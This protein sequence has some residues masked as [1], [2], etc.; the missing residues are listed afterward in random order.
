MRMSAGVARAVSG[1]SDL[2]AAPPVVYANPGSVSG[3]I[4]CHGAGEVSFSPTNSIYVGQYPLLNALASQYAVASGDFGGDAWGNSTAVSNMGSMKTWLQ[5]TMGAK[6]GKVALVGISMGTL[7][8]LNYAK[9]NPSQVACVV[10]ILPAVNLNDFATNNRAGYGA[11]ALAAYGGSYSDATNGATSNPFYYAA[12]FPSIPVQLYYSTAD[13]VAL[14]TYVTG[15]MSNCPSATGTAVSTTLNHSEAAV[16]AA[17][18]YGTGG[19]LPFIASHL[20]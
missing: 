1:Q 15:F 5:S 2:F 17:P 20:T 14:P 7:T 13:T 12:S 16:A 8:A 6:S 18:L 3:V 11:S 19:V 4:Y 10:C 9:A